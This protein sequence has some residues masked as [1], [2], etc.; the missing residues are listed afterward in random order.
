[1]SPHYTKLLREILQRTVFPY[2]TVRPNGFEIGAK[3]TPIL[4]ARIVHH[5]P[6]RTLYRQR[7]PHCRSLDGISCI[8]DTSKTCLNCLERELCTPQIRLDLLAERQA[9]RLLLSHTSAKNFM[10]FEAS[11]REQKKTLGETTT[12]FR[13]IDRGRWGEL[14]FRLR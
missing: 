12:R 2:L 7:K 14:R 1:M 9:W 6:A 11:L 8:I 13:V 10:L 3:P 5:G 4:D